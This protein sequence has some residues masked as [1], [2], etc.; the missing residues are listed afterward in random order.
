MLWELYFKYSLYAFPSGK[1]KIL[2]CAGFQHYAGWNSIQKRNGGKLLSLWENALGLAD[3][4]LIF[5]L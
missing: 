2:A 5:G 3:L 1:M 4:T